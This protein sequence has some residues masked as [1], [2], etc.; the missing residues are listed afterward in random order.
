MRMLQELPPE[1]VEGRG[2]DP[3][4]SRSLLLMAMGSVLFWASVA[5]W[6]LR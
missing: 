5:V 4:A 6:I 2:V 1:L 3:A